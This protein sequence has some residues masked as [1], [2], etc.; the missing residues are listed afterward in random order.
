MRLLD[1]LRA[2]HTL[3]RQ[4][5]GSLWT[6]VAARAGGGAAADDGAGYLR[7]FRRFAGRYHHAREEDTLF[8]ALV[9][10]AEVPADRGPLRALRADHEALGALLGELAPLLER[11]ILDAAAAARLQALAHD[12]GEGLLH[13]I[14][15][16]NSVLFPESAARLGRAGVAELTGRPPT[17]EE[18]A[19]RGEGE[20]LVARH[21]PGP[22]DLERGDGCVACPSYGVRCDGI[23]RE[24]WSELEWEGFF[25]RN[26]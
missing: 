7:F 9:S 24:W 18:A 13:H 3:I 21:P 17:T 5:V 4:V 10:A 15:A 14:A 16:E 2:E 19:A 22:G 26:D 12:Y 1:E 25:Q 6:F 8:P 20:A 11:P 23:E